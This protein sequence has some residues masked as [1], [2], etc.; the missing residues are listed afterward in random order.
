[1]DAFEIFI[2]YTTASVLYI[3]QEKKSPV[4]FVFPQFLIFSFV[5][6]PSSVLRA[7]HYL[8]EPS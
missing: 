5:F 6:D 2:P 8:P 7:F 4:S 3:L 1:M